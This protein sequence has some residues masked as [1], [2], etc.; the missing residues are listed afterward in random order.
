[1]VS[2]EDTIA[3]KGIGRILFVDDEK[4]LA[5]MGKDLIERLGYHVTVKQK[6]FEALEVFRNQPD[7]FDLVITDQTMPG[8]T[9]IELARRILQIRPDIPIILC[10]GYST[11]VNEDV[12]RAQGIKEFVLKPISK[13][14]IAKLIRKV[15][16]RKH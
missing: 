1:M 8:M 10:T 6:S 7:T 5:S 13:V 9:G 2:L 12:V 15:L 3:P 4:L 14:T 16:R 11:H